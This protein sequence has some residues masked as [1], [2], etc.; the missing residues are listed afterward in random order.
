VKNKKNRLHLLL[1]PSNINGM[2]YWVAGVSY[3]QGIQNPPYPFLKKREQQETE[4]CQCY[5]S[6]DNGGTTKH[7]VIRPTS[8]RAIIVGVVEQ[9]SKPL[10]RQG[11]VHD[12][13][14]QQ[15]SCKRT[16]KKDV[17]YL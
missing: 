6:R 16:V 9:R 5:Q 10:D 4:L 2:L 12:P 7:S 11:Y 1:N 13:R 17:T 8:V 3:E 14:T 15:R